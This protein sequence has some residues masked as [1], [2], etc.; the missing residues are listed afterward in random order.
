MYILIFFSFTY[1]AVSPF[2]GLPNC[3]DVS[4]NISLLFNDSVSEQ[5]GTLFLFDF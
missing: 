1:I 2:K 4:F 5:A 3:S